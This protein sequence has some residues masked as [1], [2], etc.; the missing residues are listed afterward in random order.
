MSSEFFCSNATISFLISSD[1][2]NAQYDVYN[3]RGQTEPVTRLVMGQILDAID[4]VYGRL[5]SDPKP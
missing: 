3:S 2:L 4:E 5:A 1:T